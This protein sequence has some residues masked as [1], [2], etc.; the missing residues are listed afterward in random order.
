MPTSSYFSLTPMV[1]EISA[2]SPKSVLDIGFGYGKWGYFCREILDAHPG[3]RVYPED[4]E[5]KIDGIEIWEGYAKRL[6]WIKIFYD[7]VYVGNAGEII[8]TLGNY[9]L[10]IL[11]DV[12][13]H[14]E[15]DKGRELL[16]NSIKRANKCCLLSI[17]IGD[18]T[19]KKTICDNNHYENHLAAWS[20]EE[21]I[22]IGREFDIDVGNY[23]IQRQ[24]NPLRAE[25]CVIAYRK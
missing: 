5:V 15:K 19:D 16:C 9:D 8:K 11:G 18:W 10:V 2:T 1:Q 25:V 21:L 6:P 17:P 23:F 7:N 12:V 22:E 14:L 20:E 13:E 24:R 4:W 3:N